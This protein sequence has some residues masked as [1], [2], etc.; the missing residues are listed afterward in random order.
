M[1]AIFPNLLFEPTV[2][3]NDKTRLD[4]SKSFLSSGS[5]DVLEI[6]PDTTEAYIDVSTNKYLDWE[7]SASGTKEVSVRVT[8]G[9]ASAEITRELSVITSESDYLFSNDADLVT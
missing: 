6:K 9:S 4:G 8:V 7:Y 2:Q 1:T 5:I 3:V